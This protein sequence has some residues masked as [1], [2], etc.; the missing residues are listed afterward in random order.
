MAAMTQSITGF[1]AAKGHSARVPR[2]N[3]RDFGGAP[4]FHRILETLLAS[5]RIDRVVLDSDSEEILESCSAA[6]PD[7]ELIVRPE[8]LRGDEVAMNRLIENGFE[9]SGSDIVLQTHATNPL[10]KA[11][12]IDAA[13]DQFMASDAPSLFSVTR[14]Q[15]RLYWAADLAPVNHNP[16]ELL[17]TQDLPLIYEENSNIYI[18]RRDPFFAAGHRIMPGSI[19]YEMDPIEATDIDNEPD[20]E[21]AL[22]LWNLNHGDRGS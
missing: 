5:S 12:S 7:I 21:L 8:E 19:P 11:S 15:T 6:F 18:M 17:P 14:W 16:D 1:V 3:M 9:V 20:F 22:A 13:V 10:L 4:L 2:K